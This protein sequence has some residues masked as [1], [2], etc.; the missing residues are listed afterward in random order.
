MTKQQNDEIDKLYKELFNSLLGY[1]QSCLHDET[2][3]EEAVQDTFRIACQKPE[4]LLGSSNPRGWIRKTLKNVI[5]N[6][7]RKQETAKRVLADYYEQQAQML[8]QSED[9][10]DFEVLYQNVAGTEEL[11]IIREMT[12]DGKTYEEMSAEQGTTLGAA[13]KRIQRAKEFLRKKL[14]N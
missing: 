10:I 12:L 6:T 8:R 9:A 1:A 5:H 14:K 13:R 7:W 4:E 3:A 2:L 11:R